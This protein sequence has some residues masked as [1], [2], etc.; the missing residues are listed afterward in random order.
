VGG[1][2]NQK[3]RHPPRDKKREYEQALYRITQ[4]LRELKKTVLT[5][6]D[7]PDGVNA[8]GDKYRDTPGALKEALEI[9][10]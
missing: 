6:G 2:V 10:G 7:W 4:S 1:A 5:P 3:S 8:L 9:V